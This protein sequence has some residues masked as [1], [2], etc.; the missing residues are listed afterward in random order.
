[1][2][3]VVEPL[4]KWIQPPELDIN[5]IDV[6]ATLDIQRMYPP[7]ILADDF[8]C[9]TTGPIT[10]IFIWGSWLHDMLP[11]N[12]PQRVVFMLS[13]HE[14]IPAN[15]PCYP[16][17]YSMPGK[18]LWMREF[19]PGQFEVESYAINLTEGYYIPCVGTYWPV[20]D[21]MCWQYHFKLNPNE[22]IQ[23][24]STTNPVVYWLDVQAYPIGA[25]SPD[26][27]FGWKT[28]EQH[29][30]DDA[31]FAVGVE[32]IQPPGPWQELRYP[33]GHPLERQSIDLAFEIRTQIQYEQLNLKRRVADDWRCVSRTP[34]TAAVWWGSYIGYRYE[35]CQQ[36]EPTPA[37]TKPDYF[38]LSIWDDVP[39][40]PGDP[41]SFSHPGVKK[42]EYKAEKYD[43][44][45][46]GYDKMPHGEPNEPVFRYSVKLPDPNWFGQ[47]DIN[48]VFWFS[49]VAVYDQSEPNYPWGWT[50]HK[51]IFND[52]A[53][54]WEQNPTGLWEW[55]P[56]T[57]QTGRT[58]DMSFILFTDPNECCSCANYNH[59][60]IINFLDYA[61]FADNWQW[62]GPPGGYNNA[63]LNCDGVVN[64]KDLEIFVLQWL[65]Y[66]P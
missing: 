2:D 57:D 15:D 35:A 50:N 56:L 10:D 44:V 12:S 16:N 63:D 46:V 37:P 48:E 54:A 45:L 9:T 49:V 59:D 8:R 19:G 65:S 23:Q 51:H 32:P 27:R 17:P 62:F 39:A 29:W 40:N 38:L 61:D 6:D 36:Q 24:G 1:M 13:L 31:V 43:E 34:V 33:A 42:W 3:T 20:G 7:Q 4:T 25:T 11:Q 30:N 47:T 28:S 64:F 18:L 5:G 41:C 55:T 14:D 52:D 58:E 22:F 60:W 21:S 53:A 66:C 26:I